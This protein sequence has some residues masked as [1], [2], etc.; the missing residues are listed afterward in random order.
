MGRAERL[1]LMWN[2]EINFDVRFN[3]DRIIVSLVMDY[4]GMNLGKIIMCY[5]TRYLADKRFF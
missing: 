4:K 2:N 1:I 5:G 3:F